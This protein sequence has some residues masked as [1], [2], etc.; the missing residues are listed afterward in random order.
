MLVKKIDELDSRLQA[1]EAKCAPSDAPM[2]EEV[3]VMH[4]I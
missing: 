2:V 1:L 3:K 4:C